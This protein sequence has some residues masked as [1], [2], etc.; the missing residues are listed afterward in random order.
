MSFRDY[1]KEHSSKNSTV[2]KSFI[3]DVDDS[4][5]EQKLKEYDSLKSSIGDVGGSYLGKKQYVSSLTKS[6]QAAVQ[7]SN[8]LEYFRDKGNADAVKT[9]SSQLD[10]LHSTKDYSNFM[11][12]FEDEDD[13]NWNYAIPS[14]YKNATITDIDK[15][16]TN[17]TPNATAKG[18]GQ[19][20]NWLKT[21]R[22]RY[23]DDNALDAELS[24]AQK[25][26]KQQKSNHI[27]DFFRQITNP[28][29]TYTNT[30]DDAA[31]REAKNNIAL[32]EGEKVR[33][34]GLKAQQFISS[35][36]ASDRSLFEQFYDADYKTQGDTLTGISQGLTGSVSDTASIRRADD[37]TQRNSLLAQLKNRGYSDADISAFFSYKDTENMNQ[38][39]AEIDKYIDEHPVLGSAAYTTA[40]ILTSPIRG[41]A[42]LTGRLISDYDSP[43][44]A[45]NTLNVL[46]EETSAAVN[47]EITDFAVE[48]LGDNGLG[49][50][51]GS[52]MTLLYSAAVSS[53]ESLLNLSLAGGVN[54][55]KINGV[56]ILFGMNA[57][58]QTLADAERRGLK[59][60]SAQATALLAGFAEGFFEHFSLENISFMKANPKVGLKNAI[61]NYAKQFITEGSEEVFTDIANGLADALINGG[62]SE[63]EQN[64]VAYMQGGMNGDDARTQAAKDVASQIGDS[65]IVGGLAGGASSVAVSISNNAAFKRAYNSAVRSAGND[66]IANEGGVDLLRQMA[67]EMASEGY[68]IDKKTGNLIKKYESRLSSASQNKDGTNTYEASKKNVKNAGRLYMAL[69]DAVDT[70]EIYRAAGG[71]ELKKSISS[72]LTKLGVD[73]QSL[74]AVTNA[75]YKSYT[76]EKLSSAEKQIVGIKAAQ[77]TLSELRSTDEGYSNEWAK[78]GKQSADTAGENAES[79]VN[80]RLM[81]AVTDDARTYLGGMSETEAKTREAKT[82]DNKTVTIARRISVTRGGVI[83]ETT[84]GEKV[85]VATSK[86]AEAPAS[87]PEVT[88]DARFRE[89]LNYSKLFEN[90]AT[91]NFFSAAINDT[92][93]D[94]GRFAQDFYAVYSQGLSGKM[95]TAPANSILS[96]TQTK[97]AYSLGKD[98]GMKRAVKSDAKGLIADIQKRNMRTGAITDYVS[99]SGKKNLSETMKKQIDILEAYGKKNNLSFVIV[100]T[101]NGGTD[102]GL[103]LKGTNKIIVALDAESGA[104]LS[105]AGHEVGHYFRDNFSGEWDFLKSFVLKTLEENGYDLE[106]RRAELKERYGT[107]DTDFIDE[108]IVCNSM[109]DVIGNEQTLNQLAEEHPTL[110]GEIAKALKNFLNKLNEIIKDLGRKWSE[111]KALQNNV[112]ALQTISTM[113]DNVLNAYNQDAAAREETDVQTNSSEENINTSNGNNSVT[114]SVKRSA[115]SSDTL[116]E[117]LFDKRKQLTDLERQMEEMKNSSEFQNLLSESVRTDDIDAFVKKY[118]NYMRTSG[119]EQLSKDIEALK[120]DV[121]RLEK[122]QSEAYANEASETEKRNIE[123]SGKT[124][125]EYFISQAAKEFGYTPYYYDAGY[126]LPNGKLLNF[127]GKKGQHFGS[128]GQDHRAIGTIFENESGSEALVRFMSYGNIRVMDETPGVDIFDGAE[129]TAEQYRALRRYISSC[130]DRGYFSVDFTGKDGYSSG[131]L[132]YENRFSADRVINDIK[133]YFETGELREQS[134]V[135]KFRYSKKSLAER[136]FYPFDS[137]DRYDEEEYNNF[138]WVNVNKILN[139]GEAASWSTQF[140]DYKKRRYYFPTTSAGEV[141]I[142]AHDGWGEDCHLVFVKGTIEKPI[143]T[144]V[145]GAEG[146]IYDKQEVLRSVINYEESSFATG[147]SMFSDFASFFGKE[148]LTERSSDDYPSYSRIQAERKSTGSVKD[149]AGSPDGGRSGGE[150]SENEIKYSRKVNAEDIAAV[151]TIK[152]ENKDL[153]RANEILKQE[154]KLTNGLML[155]RNNARTVAKN[156]MNTFGLKGADIDKLESDIYE[157][158]RSYDKLSGDGKNEDVTDVLLA[159]LTAIGRKLI[160]GSEL[161]DTTLK[162]EY[163]DVLD[164]VRK[165]RFRLPAEVLAQINEDG[166]YA[167]RLANRAR[168]TVSEDA[169][170]LEAQY[171]QLVE[172]APEFFSESDNEYEQPIKLL[173]FFEAMKPAYESTE[174]ALGFAS[175]DEAAVDFAYTT[176]ERASSMKPLQTFADKKKAETEE[177]I[178]KLRKEYNQKIS[179]A[180]KDARVKAE[181]RRNKY[182]HE[183]IDKKRD[184]SGRIKLKNATVKKVNKLAALLN[185]PTDKQ[186]IPEQL[187]PTITLFCNIFDFAKDR[188]FDEGRMNTLINKVRELSAEDY[189]SIDPELIDRFAEIGKELIGKR[190]SLMT[191][192]QAQAIADFADNIYHQVTEAN[193]VFFN[194]RKQDRRALMDSA[195]NQLDGEKKLKARNDK[196]MKAIDSI[197]KLVVTGN[198]KPVYFFDTLGGVFKDAFHDVL[199]GQ[200]KGAFLGKDAKEFFNRTAEKYKLID[201][202][203]SKN[204]YTFTTERG[205]KVVLN[206]GE[207][208]GIYATAKREA[209]SEQGSKHLTNGGIRFKDNLKLDKDGKTG[210]WQGEPTLLTVNDLEAITKTLNASQRE[211]VDAMVK[212]LSED[213]AALGNETSMLLYGYKKFGE[214]YYYPF[215]VDND[216]IKTEIGKNNNDNT[217]RI[218][219]KSFTKATQKGASAPVVV[220]NFLEVWGSH[221]SEMILYNTMAIP[222]D[223]LLLLFNAKQKSIIDETNAKNNVPDKMAKSLIRQVYGD[224][225]TQYYRI[226]LDDMS[227]G[228]TPDPSE[229]TADKLIGKF[230]KNAVFANAS[231][232]IQQ[233]SAI[234]R[235][236][237]YFDPKYFVT[238]PYSKGAYEEMLKYCGTAILK[239]IGGHDTSTG[240]SMA[241][242]ITD[243]KPVGAK[244]KAKAFFDV[245]DS[246]YRDDVFSIGA[247]KADALTWIYIWEAAKNETADKTGLTGEALLVAAGER[248]DDVIEHTQVYDSILTRSQFMRSKTTYMKML[249]AFLGEPTVSLNLV[250][251]GMMDAI[252]NKSPQAVK[253]AARSIG[254][255]VATTALNALLK[256]IISGGRDDDDKKTYLEKYLADVASNFTG[257]LFLV[258]SLPLIKDVISV[259]EGYDVERADMA[260]FGD[261][262]DALT[263]IDRESSSL[264][265]KIEAV[266]R[267]I[268]AFTGVPLGN[269]IRDVR[270]VFNVFK[271]ADMSEESWQRIIF[272]TGE[273]FNRDYKDYKDLFDLYMQGKTEKA[274]DKYAN[275]EAYLI[276]EGDS[277]EEAEQKIESKLKQFLGEAP[278]TVATA[279]KYITGD[280]KGYQQYISDMTKNGFDEIIASK[281]VRSIVSKVSSA[282]KSEVNGDTEAYDKTVAEL[283]G[284]G[285]NEDDLLKDIA[286]F[287]AEPSTSKE[288]SIWKAS[289]YASAVRKGDK[290][291]SQTIYDDLTETENATE[292]SLKSALKAEFADDYITGNASQ[293]KKIV[294]TLLGTG[295][296][297]D[298]REKVEDVVTDWA[299]DSVKN[300]FNSG[301]ITYEKA[302][303]KIVETGA[304]DRNN[305][306]WKVREWKAKQNLDEGESYSKYDDFIS[307][308]ESN[309]M[310]AYNKAL[311]EFRTYNTSSGDTTAEKNKKLN[312]TL[313]GQITSYFKP[314]YVA[315]SPSE[316]EKLKKV[317]LTY[318]AKLNYDYTN[319]INNWLK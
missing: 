129:P 199:R 161:E 208:M 78:Q 234:L 113:V 189:A 287:D 315:A 1:V 153:R 30:Y 31:E 288:P 76:G 165:L 56:D 70:G 81:A 215:K 164:F 59:G 116:Y 184:K 187:R 191:N 314:I 134:V 231:V 195:I 37:M 305:A 34:D 157:T 107:T 302:M 123:K 169:M 303:S 120:A 144:R 293:R 263:T 17:L 150:D 249:T 98:D 140:A 232:I 45:Y 218:R 209:T 13:Y 278:E 268:G 217:V 247:E 222:Q 28:A 248:F 89:I 290:Q 238:K 80:R 145:I 212:Y 312:S 171:S 296:Y 8:L 233:P 154:L 5:V 135:D 243:I 149:N 57:Y 317:L 214:K 152:R 257:D 227:G 122:E 251:Y 84:D 276:F 216:Y 51:V 156:M 106:A 261:L 18:T 158:F 22:S 75:V 6:S 7:A 213:M 2:Y 188:F 193:K 281:A 242:W 300:E 273:E 27:T 10:A 194:K 60:S 252:K 175:L 180:R 99:V 92:Q 211:F 65:F 310:T 174:K 192:E 38:T 295:L 20:L 11:T 83:A 220:D 117:E 306:Y 294:D 274:A 198:M 61:L 16:I 254:A 55:G 286:S 141:M 319:N 237:A 133:N 88:P 246:S 148:L 53:A 304:M 42:S 85:F 196:V 299:L 111:V 313:A 173:D 155:S 230:K 269:I 178:R 54:I 33:R 79:S 39:R 316:R 69:G 259:F 229:A 245:T 282:A 82:E 71:T 19:E 50:F 311:Y 112:T 224:A 97:L 110:L 44:S 35:L 73:E 207:I 244:N 48:K 226:L 266:S 47:K 270:A 26:L 177:K 318:Y 190:M 253:F 132:E 12:Q 255:F 58:S 162:D 283:L 94:V 3:T 68:G 308:I 225:F 139:I 63:Y 205:D 159:E 102:N 239:E 289:D 41:V 72:R 77:R 43:D 87:L 179:E 166:N 115:K 105:V 279:H 128:R 114:S 25:A 131:S 15:A 280:V 119:M 202:Y 95:L 104:L 260:V 21:F 176:L 67:S 307:A 74:E 62:L 109:F 168:Y 236:L 291:L 272:A 160:D 151:N 284:L 93:A 271:S 228:I 146:D 186:H 170:T 40:S 66:I 125:S 181:T 24:T 204:K 256:S 14:K 32:L 137:I 147:Y 96:E 221:V 200:S 210:T 203:D 235:A 183:L 121:D 223:N 185:S 241:S 258:N 91:A 23:L 127:S 101:I 142:I 36:P 126:M 267:A 250:A 182:Y 285:Y 29:G 167:K 130:T 206:L 219:N 46:S 64:V 90:N 4:N 9:L 240:R 201:W 143:I 86:D 298:S 309:D 275:I 301:K 138:G 297:G 100:D 52:G 124:E 49:R 265:D 197:K 292:G 264:A 172:L 108:E 103:Y 262:V 118:A 277:E 136:S 163:S